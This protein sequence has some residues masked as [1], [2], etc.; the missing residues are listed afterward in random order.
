MATLPNRLNNTTLDPWNFN[1][2]GLAH[3]GMVP[4]LIAD[5]RS[6]GVTDTYLQPLFRS[7]EAYV[8]CGSA[9]T[10]RRR[11]SRAAR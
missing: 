8:A 5:L 6:V 7:A 1:V 11:R 4:D 9:P 2:D 3:A 10:A